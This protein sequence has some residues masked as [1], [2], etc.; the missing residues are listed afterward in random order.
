M[1]VVILDPSG[2]VLTI[3]IFCGGVV[4]IFLYFPQLEVCLELSSCTDQIQ[5][6]LEG[7]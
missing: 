3:Q 1:D 7:M 5:L 2:L 4:Y 6:L